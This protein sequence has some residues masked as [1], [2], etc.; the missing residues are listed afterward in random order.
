M[1]LRPFDPWKSSVCTCPAKLSLNPYTGCPHGCLYCY[2][3]SYIPQFQDCRPKVDLHKRLEREAAKIK[4]GT[5]VAMS[6]SSDPYPLMENN[7]RLSRG[8][9][10]ILKKRGLRV[11]IVTKSDL[12]VDDADL[13]SSMDAMV[14][15]TITTL[16]ESLCKKLEPGTV[17]PERRLNAITRLKKSGIPISARIDP[18]IPGI[19]DSEIEDLVL[20]V[21]RAGAMHITS[22]CYKARPDNLRR[23]CSIFPREGEAL[24]ALL[25]SGCRLGGYRYL[26]QEM[27]RG[28][29]KEMNEKAFQ[30]GVTFSTCR[31][32]FAEFGCVNCDGSH[33]LSYKC[34]GYSDNKSGYTKNQIQQIF[35][36]D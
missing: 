26:P 15:V 7:L 4:P 12:V 34:Q 3:S 31:E 13:I 9:L 33:L 20:A 2:A 30:K 36:K 11:Q 8:C 24:K 16:K 10:E 5:L 27:R 32:G 19:N 25:K 21:C 28:L 1:I 29:M 18:I 22:S 14:A 6:N 23:I 35:A 17:S